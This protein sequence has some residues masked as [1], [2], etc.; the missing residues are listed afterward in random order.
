[1]LLSS[2]GE[3]IP[4]SLIEVLTGVGI[5]A[6][7]I[8]SKNLLYFN[9]QTLLPDLG[10]TKALDI[11]GFQYQTKVFDKPE[12][13]PIDELRRDLK[14]SP[15]VIGPLDMSLLIYNPNHKYLKGADHFALAYDL[16]EKFLYVHDPA[17]FPH[18]F[19]PLKQ[20]KESWQANGVSYKK[21]YYRYTFSPKRIES[22][23]DREIYER[24]LNFF[25]KI[26]QEG[27]TQTDR[28]KYGIGG[29]AIREFSAFIQKNGL[30]E[31]ERG[32]FVYFV[33]PLGSKRALDYFKFFEP[34]NKELSRLK[35]QQSKIFGTAHTHAVDKDW[36]S[37]TKAF[38]NL[39]EVEEQFKNALLNF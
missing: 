24:A 27:E 32:H 37:L 34:F 19:L 17:G 23:S 8:R 36:S 5:G 35:Y 4:S 1:M 22:P 13:F 29:E 15:A 3:N 20:L 6:T 10:L 7:L 26:Y 18:V 2:I 12:D 11:L 30:K 16:D 28:N 39:A 25:K 38:L 21:G 31:K 9:N 33:L 14:I